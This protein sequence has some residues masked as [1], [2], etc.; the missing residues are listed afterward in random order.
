MPAAAGAAAAAAPAQPHSRLGL[1]AAGGD[2]ASG[3]LPAAAEPGAP[4]GPLPAVSGVSL[5]SGRDL[6]DT[7][8]AL[9]LAA[10]VATAG[11]GGGG[12]PGP[13]NLGPGAGLGGQSNLEGESR[14]DGGADKVSERRAAAE[15]R[16]QRMEAA[17]APAGTKCALCH[18]T[19]TGGGAT[20]A[21]RGPLPCI[22]CRAALGCSRMARWPPPR[23]AGLAPKSVPS[24]PAPGPPASLPGADDIPEAA[25][26]LGGRS[27]SGLGKMIL[28]RVSGEQRGR[29]R[30]I[31]ASGA[32]CAAAH[33]NVLPRVCRP[34]SIACPPACL[35][36]SLPKAGART[37]SSCGWQCRTLTRSATARCSCGACVAARP[38][39][40][41]VSRS[42]RPRVRPPHPCC[43]L[44]SLVP[45]FMLTSVANKWARCWCAR[46]AQA[47]RRISRSVTGDA[48][49]LHLHAPAC[50]HTEQLQ[51]VS[52]SPEFVLLTLE[53]RCFRP[54]LQ[55]EQPIGGD[56]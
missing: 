56:A 32:A 42:V 46:V 23:Q 2:G 10:T 31:R 17:G 48:L 41:L 52:S 4:R 21:G 15:A 8:R 14:P 47:V 49:A 9:S 34:A 53:S 6:G 43:S 45:F 20:S 27:Q 28:V 24:C 26:G 12:G 50:R 38:V 1:A 39:C 55:G 30:E 54:R 25:R 3:V 7:P 40:P 11:G 35:P 19:N 29:P 22:P 36:A 13:S 44:P 37:P 5:G 51:R 16:F 33:H 18:G